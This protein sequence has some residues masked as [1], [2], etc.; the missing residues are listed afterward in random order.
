MQGDKKAIMYEP[1]QMDGTV[2]TNVWEESDEFLV[3]ESNS[4]QSGEVALVHPLHRVSTDD[5]ARRYSHDHVS[6]A[7]LWGNVRTRPPALITHTLS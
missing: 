1:E 3:V 2:S 6:H 5:V 7:T 4:L